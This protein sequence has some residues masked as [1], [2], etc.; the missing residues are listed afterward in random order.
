MYWSEHEQLH[1]QSFLR[2]SPSIINRCEHNSACNYARHLLTT[3]TS[4]G[5]FYQTIS[6]VWYSSVGALLFNLMFTANVYYF[7]RTNNWLI[8]NHAGRLAAECCDTLQFLWSILVRYFVAESW[9][10]QIYFDWFFNFCESLP[11][12]GCI[13]KCDFMWDPEILAYFW[14]FWLAPNRG[15]GGEYVMDGGNFV[16]YR[17]LVV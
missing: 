5:Q 17:K 3:Y 10:Q 13:L 6:I 15:G 1:L 14:I 2:S 8:P 12:N 9:V 16:V 7:I 4:T 11:P